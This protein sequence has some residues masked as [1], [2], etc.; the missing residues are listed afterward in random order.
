MLTPWCPT[1]PSRDGPLGT[2]RRDPRHVPVG[3]H[4]KQRLC[5]PGFPSFSHP[6]FSHRKRSIVT[7]LA[8]VIFVFPP[9]LT[10]VTRRTGTHAIPAVT[11]T[12]TGVDVCV[13]DR[14]GARY[15]GTGASLVSDVDTVVE[16]GKEGES[17]DPFECT[18]LTRTLA[19]YPTS[20]PGPSSVYTWPTCRR[21]FPMETQDCGPWTLTLK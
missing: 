1:A 13:P 14:A 4:S 12:I 3:G 19:P 16:N 17:S 7:T 6:L 11:P 8:S 21:G 20:Y 18:D 2:L 10:T 5:H 9:F 15:R